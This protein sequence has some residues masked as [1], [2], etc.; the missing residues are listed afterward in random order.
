MFGR[1][2]KKVASTQAEKPAKK[3]RTTRGNSKS[4]PG[5]TSQT[6]QPPP[7]QPLVQ[8]D[9]RFVSETA[10]LRYAQIRRCKFVQEKG[11]G[12]DL[13]K[14]V[15]EINRELKRRKWVTFN[16][17][18]RKVENRP[19]NESW[20][21]EFFAN[22]SEH[23]SAGEPGTFKALVRGKEIDFSPIALNKFLGTKVY[24]TPCPLYL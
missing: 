5:G 12:V 9:Q 14:V 1:G 6:A 4:G 17:I 24:E 19:G 20:A 18:L 2:K 10:A 21:R 16:E 7:P 13:L 11:F 22:A 15:P 8:H 23:K 3:S